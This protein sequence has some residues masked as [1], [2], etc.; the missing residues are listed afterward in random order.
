MPVKKRFHINQDNL[1]LD[2]PDC[3]H[4]WLPD[5]N[6]KIKN[7]VIC[8]K[9]HGQGVSFFGTFEVGNAAPQ[10]VITFKE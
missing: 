2:C 4:E 1:N 8:R 5:D 3:E 10:G 7:A 6:S 9:C